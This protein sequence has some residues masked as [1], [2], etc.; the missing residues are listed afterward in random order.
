MALMD[1]KCIRHW[2]NIYR[3]C[4]QLLSFVLD[5]SPYGQIGVI[6]PKIQYYSS[7]PI[8]VFY[9][10]DLTSAFI[11]ESKEP[12]QIPPCPPP[13][14]PTPWLNWVK[15]YLEMLFCRKCPL[16][17]LLLWISNVLDIIRKTYTD[18]LKK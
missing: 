1:I 12:V 3:E 16:L 13:P 17:L 15:R 9:C 18:N 8:F 7:L 4:K 14:S 11:W 5:P 6:N 10:F 2:E